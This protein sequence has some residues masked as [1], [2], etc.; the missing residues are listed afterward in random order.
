[1]QVSNLERQLSELQCGDHPGMVYQTTAEKM[2][3]IIPFIKEGLTKGGYCV[4]VADE[5]TV[6][7]VADALR[8]SGIDVAEERERGCLHFLTKLEYRRQPELK[9][10]VMSE[11]VCG[12]IGQALGKGCAG[13][14]L[15]VEMAWTL[16]PG[17]DHEKLLQ[18]EALIN[19]LQEE[20]PAVG[21]CLYNRRRMAPPVLH[22][23]LLTHPQMVLGDQVHPNL[24]YE[25]PHLATARESCAERVDWMLAQFQRLQGQRQT[26]VCQAEELSYSQEEFRLLIEGVKDYAIF[27]LDPSGYIATWN[28]GAQQI[29][30]YRAG[31][32]IGQH[33]SRFYP[34]EDV[35]KG[36]PQR[37]LQ[38]A[39]AEGRAED[40]GWRVRK[41]GTRFWADVIIT[42]LRDQEGQLRGFA[43]V[44]RDMTERRKAEEER[45]KLLELAKEEEERQH[46][47]ALIDTSP[48][49]VLLV[50]ART[51]RVVL[52]N[53]EFQRL[54]GISY[55][56]GKTLAECEQSIIYRKPDGQLYDGEERPLRR[57]LNHGETVRAEEVMVEFPEDGRTIQTLV[58]TTPIL[59]PQGQITSAISIVQ[60]L[61]PREELEKLR[62][63]F[64]GMV[65]HELRTPLS[66]IKG[67]A[68][69]AL[70]SRI[71]LSPGENLQFFQI[72][73][74]QVDRLTDLVNDLLDMSRIE[75][76]AFEVNVEST[77]L[78]SVLEEAIAG[79]G[80]TY[81]HHQVQLQIPEG[82]PA[83]E[84]DRSRIVQVLTNL[85]NNAASISPATAPITIEVE[86]AA[87]Y[88]TVHVRDCG[89]GTS[90]ER[91]SYLFKKFAQID[92]DK[93]GK[94]SWIGLSLAICKGVVEAHGGRIWANSSKEGNGTTISFTLPKAGEASESSLAGSPAG[95]VHAAGTTV[96][97]EHL[98]IL[99]VDDD[100]NALTFLRRLLD[101]AGYRP[102]LTSDPREA[103]ELVELERPDLVLLDLMLPGTSGLDLMQS[104]R[105]FSDV[106]VVFL[107]ARN[108]RDDMVSALK[109]GGDDYITKPFS[110]SE[111]LARVE[112]VLRRKSML[113]M[114][115]A[116]PP[117]VLD[118]LTINFDERRVTV[119]GEEISLSATQYKL[120]CQLTR[121]AGRVL[122]YDQILQY[123][124]GRDYWGET[125]LVRSMVRS[126]RHR[127]GDNARNPRYI[128]TIPQVGYRMPVSSAL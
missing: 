52:V 5:S 53:P 35:Q 39:I 47:Q 116:T 114:A 2:S 50:D 46:L 62:N 123:V 70:R 60:D 87:G 43:K 115:E 65:G 82:L 128:F 19:T 77:D 76:G 59:N 20:S 91:L 99:V 92:E 124:W 30:G 84:A 88:L 68:A 13:L 121:Y 54:R 67:A 66:T 105:Q 3:A 49:G 42:A 127:L 34:E 10:E 40:E 107:T 118:G 33:Y 24:Y 111:L 78:P 90:Q 55:Q 36:K 37:L 48:V 72:I 75:A 79:F 104:I 80:R 109:M 21:L 4:Y 108:T 98:Q 12:M 16:E 22:A 101:G 57:A 96:Q 51:H 56:P 119:G 28:T 86:P 85:L 31:E 64:L 83:V 126:L 27:L 93:G 32:I 41:D 9:L 18:W 29:K 81:N 69:T 11:V 97:D 112:A 102:I 106:P 94:S 14:W 23:A 95:A 117:Y 100:Q 17:V 61:T 73:E 74:E 125:E 63:E 15:A 122:T 8:A 6:G 89:R 103:L 26:L 38:V 45:I 120:L 1:M 44:T 58:N 25:P 110:E 113:G 71:S 7:E